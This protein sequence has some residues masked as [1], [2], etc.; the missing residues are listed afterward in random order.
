MREFLFSLACLAGVVILASCRGAEDNSRGVR[1]DHPVEYSVGDYL[2]GA[3]KELTV[4]LGLA[5]RASR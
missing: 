2:S 5:R 4:A 1:P 3:D